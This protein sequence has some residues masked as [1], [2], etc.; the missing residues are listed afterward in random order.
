MVDKQAMAFKFFQIR[1]VGVCSFN[2][3][4]GF[5]HFAVMQRPCGVGW[6]GFDT[7]GNSSELY[8]LGAHWFY[9]QLRDPKA[10]LQLVGKIQL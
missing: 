1:Q 3:I 9:I 4:D 5:Q 6:H 7:T 2:G 10:P 8:T